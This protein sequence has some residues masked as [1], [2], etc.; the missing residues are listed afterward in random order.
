MPC[1]LPSRKTHFGKGTAMGRFD[2]L[3]AA[4]VAAALSASSGAFGAD[5]PLAKLIG[6]KAGNSACFSR[7]YDA[8]HLK[9]HPAQATTSVLLSLK[10]DVEEEPTV[11]IAL[12]PKGKPVRYV[13]GQ[14]HWSEEVNR[15]VAGKRLIKAFTK[16]AGFQCMAIMARDS[17]E[18]GGDFP[19]D[20]QPDGASLLLYF[21]DTVG[22]FSGTD[23]RR[24]A[25]R[26]KLGTDDRIFRLN[27]ADGGRCLSMER[28]L[29]GQ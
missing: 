19:L 24:R 20:L 1:S 2:L 9:R 22:A 27:R 10:Y 18:E 12:A 13:V 6:A 25:T 8:A 26:I 11:R 5:D 17:A 4:I 28:D 3:K 29:V 15:D 7:T 16:D 21:D 14:C 23:T